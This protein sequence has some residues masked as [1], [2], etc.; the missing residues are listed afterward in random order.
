MHLRDVVLIL[1]NLV[2]LSFYGS[3]YLEVQITEPT[4]DE[5]SD[6]EVVEVQQGKKVINWDDFDILIDNTQPFLYPTSYLAEYPKP[7]INDEEKELVENPP[8]VVLR[9]LGR[10]RAEYNRDVVDPFYPYMLLRTGQY[11]GMYISYFKVKM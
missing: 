6:E 3:T 7:D 4:D 11:P 8:T 9:C 10:K 1:G 2:H 5:V